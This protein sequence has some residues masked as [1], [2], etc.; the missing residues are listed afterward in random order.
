MF[1][2]NYTIN[3]PTWLS[4]EIKEIQGSLSY[5]VLV[6]DGR[7]VKKHVDQIR[8]RMVTVPDTSED[9]FLPT[10]V[11]GLPPPAATTIPTP[12]TP[13]LRCSS[14]IRNPPDHF[15]PNNYT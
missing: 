10:P 12:S 11:V 8:C 2:R 6:L 14:R 4:G 1:V 3:G 13:A 15:S 5:T 7:P 9:D